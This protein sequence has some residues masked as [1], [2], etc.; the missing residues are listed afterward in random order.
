MTGDA[1]HTVQS[2]VPCFYKSCLV[3]FHQSSEKSQFINLFASLCLRAENLSV[4]M[5][6]TGPKQ[7]RIIQQTLFIDQVLFSALK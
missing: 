3:S 4:E 2:C 6:V 5:L 1:Q 7:T